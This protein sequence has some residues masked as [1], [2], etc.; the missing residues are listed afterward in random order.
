MKSAE[1]QRILLNSLLG[2]GKVNVEKAGIV[3]NV[4]DGI[5]RVHGLKKVQAGELV[6]FSAGI[7]GMALNLERDSVG[8][9]IF[10]N[11]RTIRQGDL[12]ERTGQ[13]VDIPVGEGLLGRCVDALGNPVDGKG[14]LLNV[15]RS[16]V[17]VKAPGILLRKSVHEPVQT[18]IKAI[19]A[20]LP[21]GRGQR[22]LI[23]GDRQT[24]KTAIAVDTIINQRSV[25]YDLTATEDQKLVCIYVAIGQ[26]RS[27]VLQIVNT[28]TNER[29]MDYSV[30]VAATSSESASVQFLAP[31]AGCAIGEFFRD[32]GRHALIIYDDLSKQAV[33]YRQMSLLLRRPPGR[34]AYPGD[35]FY[36]HS[37][38]LERAAKM[39][40]KVGHGSLTALPVVETQAGD[41]SAYIPTNVI[42]ITDGQIF[43]ET[44][45]FYKGI[46]PAINAGLSVSRVGSAAQLKTMRKV[47]GSLKLELAQYR[48]I[49]S[50]A[51]F[52]SDLDEATQKLLN[53]G[54][55]LTEL[56]KQPQ[57]TPFSIE[58]QVISIFVGVNGYFDNVDLS[59]VLP[60]EKALL[61]YF[62]NTA[63][64]YPYI[65]LIKE[66]FDE[67]IFSV[68][69]A[70]ARIKV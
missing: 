14:P 26:K 6:T 27:T 52:G 28:L 19:D 45:L 2:K 49:A 15:E 65:R 3:L 54:S 51:Q 20:L 62:Y 57:Y 24:G 33:A 66:E 9:V 5:A 70:S 38:L 25:N 8:V 59:K 7:T 36:L 50:F 17:E 35:V 34:E 42:S 46:R 10:G 44:E 69:L 43:L 11:D 63:T 29:A 22:E 67:S 32:K 61:D 13:I 21:I 1:L 30:V 58:S 37:R 55:H 31:Y 18:G 40:D 53:R 56:L 47:S 12:V 64:F 48:E 23:I 4:G 39:A 41:V 60:T 68:I 16:R